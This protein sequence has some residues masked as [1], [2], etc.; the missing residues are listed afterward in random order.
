MPGHHT[1]SL[2]CRV[3][4]DH[5]EITTFFR[6]VTSRMYDT[7][8]LDD[9]WQ[10]SLA[11]CPQESNCSGNYRYFS[12][13][14]HSSS[15]VPKSDTVSPKSVWFGHLQ[16]S[17]NWNSLQVKILKGI[18]N[19]EVWLVYVCLCIKKTWLTIGKSKLLGREVVWLITIPD[20][21]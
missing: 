18:K 21:K 3:F 4:A 9:V 10:Q 20:L 11:N 7:T 14:Q 13:I 15:N 2:N 6:P 12:R 8:M 5:N 16:W 17:R 19:N 1:I